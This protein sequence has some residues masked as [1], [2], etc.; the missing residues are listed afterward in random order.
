MSKLFSSAELKKMAAT[1]DNAF[2][3]K[4]TKEEF[5]KMLAEYTKVKKD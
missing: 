4:L 2:H 1:C 3:K 5:K